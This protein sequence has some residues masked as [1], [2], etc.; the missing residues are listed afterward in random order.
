MSSSRLAVLLVADIVEYSRMMA[1]DESA[2]IG[3]VQEVNDRFL[4]PNIS[5]HSGEILKRMG[6]GWIV[7]FST[8]TPAIECAFKVLTALRGHRKIRLRIGGHI[9]EI[10]DDGSDIYG[11]AINIAA[12]LQAEAPP[13]GLVI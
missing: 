4:S 13:G 1:E 3:F 7:A 9:G 6:D 8:I 10:T 5:D 2:T 12:R 11:S